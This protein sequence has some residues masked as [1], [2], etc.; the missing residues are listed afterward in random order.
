MERGQQQRY[1]LD[2]SI[3]F[4]EP[5]QDEFHGLDDSFVF[6]DESDT[7]PQSPPSEE[8]LAARAEI[9]E[10]LESIANRLQ[11]GRVGAMGIA[12]VYRDGETGAASYVTSEASEYLLA[13]RLQA[14]QYD[15]LAMP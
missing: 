13:G 10:F 1:S 5:K 9:A 12:V 14:L 4:M 7:P 6:D 15:I 11:D 3:Y 8:T 2:R